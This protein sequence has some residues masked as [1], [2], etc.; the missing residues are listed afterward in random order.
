[1]LGCIET[2]DAELGATE[3]AIKE[4]D[5]WVCGSNSPVIATYPFHELN[6]NGLPNDEG[7]QVVSLYQQGINYHLYVEQG[8]I[9]GRVGSLELRDAALAGAQIRLRLGSR[10]FS[11][12]ISAVG[13]VWTFARLNGLQKQLQTYQL[14][15]GEIIGGVQPTRWVNL[16]SNPPSR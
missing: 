6:I 11:I 12:Q 8:K 16:C 2:P 15:V 14:D 3:Q 10:L 13:S 5:T 4:C 7:F 1:A 9:V